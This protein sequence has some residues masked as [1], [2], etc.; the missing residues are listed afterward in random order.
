MKVDQ[1]IK[2]VY[3]NIYMKVNGPFILF[4]VFP[5]KIRLTS[6]I[7]CTHFQFNS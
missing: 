3:G 5:L 4:H 6:A 2:T 1:D 7:C